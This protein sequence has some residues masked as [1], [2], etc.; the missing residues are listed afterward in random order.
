MIHFLSS[1]CVCA[2]CRVCCV[3]VTQ[4]VC[5][6]VCVC[7]SVWWCATHCNVMSCPTCHDCHVMTVMIMTF[8]IIIQF[9]YNTSYKLQLQL[10]KKLQQ[11]LSDSDSYSYRSISIAIANDW[12]WKHYTIAN[13][14]HCTPARFLFLAFGTGSSWGRCDKRINW[15]TIFAVVLKHWND[16][17]AWPMCRTAVTL[18]VL[19]GQGKI[20]RF[21]RC[22]CRVVTVVT[23]S[24]CHIRKLFEP[25]CELWVSDQ[26]WPGGPAAAVVALL[27]SGCW[28]LTPD[29]ARLQTPNLAQ[30]TVRGRT[31]E[32]LKGLKAWSPEGWRPAG[33]E[34]ISFCDSVLA[35]SLI[36]IHHVYYIM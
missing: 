23:L 26:P 14:S 25:I 10:Y 4:C 34:K 12:K 20:V 29:S 17:D 1:V 3:C 6:C 24:H 16:A 18:Q 8:I 31:A 11:W 35:A 13:R 30:V 28:L 21:V 9:I 15:E 22:C 2:V 7:V 27:S 5:A 33:P 19:Q 32:G 36:L